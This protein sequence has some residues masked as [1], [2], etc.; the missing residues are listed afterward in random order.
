MR[1]G[2]PLLHPM[3]PV[4]VVFAVPFVSKE[5]EVRDGRAQ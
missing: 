3:F 4:F 2:G 5:V 1:F